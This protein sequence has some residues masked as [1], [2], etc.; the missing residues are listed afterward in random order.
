MSPKQQTSLHEESEEEG[1]K[2][3]GEMKSAQD[4]LPDANISAT[5]TLS[6]TSGEIAQVCWMYGN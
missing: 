2:E 3:D 1:E 4:C 6:S 5:T